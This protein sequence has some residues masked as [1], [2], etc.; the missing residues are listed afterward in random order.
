MGGSAVNSNELQEIKFN[1]DALLGRLER[2]TEDKHIA[3]GE[4]HLHQATIKIQLYS[5][6]LYRVL[7][8]Y[9]VESTK[10]R[11]CLCENQGLKPVQATKSEPQAKVIYNVPEQNR[12]FESMRTG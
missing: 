10:G 4:F 5:A 12:Y 9:Q 11:T 8:L 1:I 3:A 2:I 7:F 6:H